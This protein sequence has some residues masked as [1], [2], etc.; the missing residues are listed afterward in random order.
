MKKFLAIA[1]A[2]VM[3]LG[4]FAGC[5]ASNE[6]TPAG[7]AADAIAD[8][9]TSADGKYQVAF[10][11]DV[12]QL[13][14]KSFNQGTYD[15][16]KLYASANNKSYKYYQPANGNEAT[17]DDRVDAMKLA[18]DNGAEVV[19]AAGF[20]QEGALKAA[21]E[22]YPDVHFVFIDGYP[23]GFDNVAGI[24][25]QEEQS[26]YLAGYAAVMEGYTKLGF[27]GGGGGTNP[28]CQRFGY[29]FLQG[30]DAAA[31]AKGI[32]VEMNYS[33][34]YGSSFSASPELQAMATGWYTNGTEVIFACGGSMFQSVSAAASAEDGKVVGVDVD[35]SF[36]SPAVITSAM[37]GLAD[38]AQWAIA[39]HYDGKW[40]EIG[41]TSTS[42]GAKDNAVG[43]P[44]ATWS[45]TGWSVADYE[46]MFAKLVAGEM[47]ISSDLVLA[48][49]STANVTVTYVE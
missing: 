36:E 10:V 7:N 41:G 43:L 24:A 6:E 28:A 45:L 15:G 35:Q 40:A 23:I 3:V 14:D 31:A 11:T 2:L 25:F 1:L 20:M 4:L 13:K 16:V 34:A 29:G 48:P 8:E 37:K 39:K 27:M 32:T 17:D 42:L 46:A 18:C 9:M 33:W 49:E 47:T 26:G 44:T 5:G 21:A 12:G 19:V 22:A 30:A 38:A